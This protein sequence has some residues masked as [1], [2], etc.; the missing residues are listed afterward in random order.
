MKKSDIYPMP[1]YF[2]RYINLVADIEILDAF[3]KSIEQL[4]EIDRDFFTKLDH[5]RYSPEKWT[6][7]DI[8]QHVIDT[9]RIFAY[10]ALRFARNDNTLLPGFDENSFAQH[11]TA[12]L[13]TIN[14]LLEEVTVL[15]K[16]NRIM[17]E[18]FDDE[19]LLRTGKCYNTKMSV[20][21]IGFNIIGHQIHHLRIIEE[22]YM[23]LIK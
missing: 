18:S 10:R 22:R 9:E 8:I 5:K 11:T 4:H 6:V 12:N 19:M 15:R 1:E 23:P 2:D 3:D 16:A 17:F 21:A 14:S 7:K 13:R 20:L